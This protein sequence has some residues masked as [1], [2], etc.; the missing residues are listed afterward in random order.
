MVTQKKPAT[1]VVKAHNL[2]TSFTLVETISPQATAP[3][4]DAE[5]LL[6]R[7]QKAKLLRRKVDAIRA[8]ALAFYKPHTKQDRF[9]RSTALRRGAFTGNRFGKSHMGVAE[10]CAWL[11]NERVWYGMTDP[12]RT[13]G[14]P[15]RP[16]KGLIIA[17][18][19]DKIKEIFTGDDG[20]VWRFL[21]SGFVR[22]TTRNHSGAVDT[23]HCTNGS[24]LRFDTVKSY[25]SNPQG[26][27][28]SDWDF[29]H[30]DEPIPEGMWKAQSR[31]LVDR[32]G[33]AWFTLTALREPWITDAFEPN[34]GFAFSQFVVEGEINDNPYLTAD[35]IAAYAAS[36]TDEEKECRLYGKPL[37]KAGLVYKEFQRDVHVLQR[38]P[39]GWKS[40]T[41]PPIDWT[42]YGYIDPH[43]H[44]PHAVLLL[45][46]DPFGAKYYWAALF[47]KCLI[48]DLC[49]II[50]RLM[51]GRRFARVR[52]DPLAF[53]EDPVHATRMADEFWNCGIAVEKA[54]KDLAR[55]ILRVKEE[56]TKKPCSLHISPECRRLV[57]ELQRYH[58]D[59]E[60]GKPVDKDDH[61]VECLYRSVLDEPVYL[62]PKDWRDGVKDMDFSRVGNLRE[63]EPLKFDE[64]TITRQDLM[65]Q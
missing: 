33:A 41:E 17:N 62:D 53:I 55:G 26:S 2:T 19:W 60:S 5:L 40:W 21:P 35:A 45:A 52:C 11:R 27:E 32:N 15:Q 65:L 28:S 18:D 9:H 8:D 49:S 64:V 43:P 6:V 13:A 61:A 10:D 47:E 7:Q 59:E 29:I 51:A 30:V 4:P 24:S 1:D 31:G 16:L 34:G 23:I 37:H 50:Q 14:I 58:W 56:L 12:A 46:V 38:L 54:S 36:L 48:R 39:V 63:E 3:E 57:W 25:L 22:S 42:Y 20:K 44:T